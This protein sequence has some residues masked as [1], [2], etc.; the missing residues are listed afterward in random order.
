MND[1]IKNA[2]TQLRVNQLKI[3]D[4]FI[5]SVNDEELMVDW[6][7]NGV[8]DEATEDDYRF[9]AESDDL[10]VDCVRIFKRTTQDDDCYY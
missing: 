6:L 5:H 2:K 9:I 4:K 3:M 7:T 10:Y 1:C 8:P